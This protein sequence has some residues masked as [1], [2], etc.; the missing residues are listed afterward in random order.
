MKLE[1]IEYL[2]KDSKAPPLLFI[3]GASHGA[4]CWRENFLPYFSSKGFSS[5]ALS[6]RGH[7]ESEGRER[8]HSFSLNDYVNDVHEAMLLLK[9]KPVLIGHSMGGAVA[10]RILY[11]YPD[12]IKAAVLMASIPPNGMMKDVLRLMF[13]NFMQY[14]QLFFFSKKNYQNILSKVFFSDD[15]P[16]KKRNEF[17]NFLQPESNKAL[18]EFTKQ[19]VPKSINTKVPMLILGSKKDY[20]FPEKTII[21]FGKKYKIEPIIFSNIS[22]DMMLDPNWKT[23][24]EQIVIF[25]NEISKPP[26]TKV[27]NPL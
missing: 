18:K 7:G 21:N 1:I 19:I 16:V 6:L 14:I 17:I 12:K 5:Y 13:T 8:I 3:H 15:L 24:A 27:H 2:S 11:L 20:I 22:H 10:Q 23:V 9:D 25:L 26:C 4:W